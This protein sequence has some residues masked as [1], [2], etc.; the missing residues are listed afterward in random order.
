MAKAARN[1]IDLQLDRLI[2]GVALRERL[3][4][5]TSEHGGDGSSPEIRRALLE[6]LKA[7][8]RQGR[9][10]AE[11]LLLEDG[12]GNACATRLSHLQDEII[13]CLYDFA[14][15][16][17]FR[18]PNPTVGEKITVAAVGGYGR[19]TLA[20]GSD[21]DL[22][23]LLPYKRTGLTEQ[24][25]EYMLYILWDMGFTVG[26]ATRSV[27]D[28]IRLSSEDMTIRTS[29][30]EARF[31][32]GDEAMFDTL[33][34]RF[35][36]EIVE[37]SAPEFIAAKLA[38]R[39]ARHEKSG[40]SRYRV[41]PNVKDGKGGLRDLH[42]LFWIAK[43]HYQV[44]TQTD[45][46]KR[47]VFSVKEFNRFT[48][49]QDFLWAV[50]CH[51]H[52]LTGREEERLSFDVQPVL[53]VRLGYQS[54]PGLSA[55][56]RFMKHY[57]LFAKDVGDLTRILCARLEEEQAKA[58]SGIAGMLKSLS[59][60]SRPKKVRKSDAFVSI[61]NRIKPV[62]E[63]VFA[64]DPRSL[65]TMF[66]LAE[67]NELLFHP[68]AMHLA[69][70]SLKLIDK[71]LR[72]DRQANAD[73]LA[74]LTSPKTPERTLRK[75]NESGVL[76]RFIPDFGKIVAM[77]QF[78]MY[79]HYTVDEHLLRSI[80]ILSEIERGELDDAHPLSDEIMRGTPHRVELY[81]ALLLHDIAKG[82]PEDHSIA[83]AKVA[84]RLCPR[85]GL[86]EGQ[87]R[88]VAWL[89]EQHL[90]M[91]TIAQSRDLTDP[92]TIAD[93]AKS[94]ESVDRMKL[95]IVLTVCDIKAVGPGV[96]NG[97]KGQLL[98]TLYYQTEPVLTGGFTAAPRKQQV[99]HA[100]EETIAALVEEKGVEA[101]KATAL[102]N[103]HYDNYWL[104]V[105]AQRRTQHAEFMLVAEETE[106]PFDFTIETHRFEGVT[107]LTLLVP[108]HPHLLSIIAGCCAVSDANI[109]DAQIF[110]L[111]DG[112]ALDIIALNR[113]FSEDED[114]V[115]RATR[116]ANLIRR[117]LE[118]TEN[119][120]K[121]LAG[122]PRPK[123]R[124]K[125]FTVEPVVR[126]DNGLSDKF[127]VIEVEGRDRTG[128]L[129]EITACLADRSLDIASAHISTF[130]EKVRDT[131]YVTD[132]TGQKIEQPQRIAALRKRLLSVLT[133][134]PAPTAKRSKAA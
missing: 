59:R 53:A 105:S 29:I 41:E 33:I 97:W 54:H 11:E 107:E 84:R 120:D 46:R 70:R 79:H 2:D 57:F 15:V 129:S 45:L 126:I 67:E 49:A 80:G 101:D 26:H 90:V 87:T 64:D 99:A 116:I 113:A 71:N 127:T 25:V 40:N 133:A 48:K 125:A 98:R 7:A 5:L 19:G 32:L 92:R 119:L 76:G 4:A 22:L 73:F 134:Q 83:G 122:R 31:L 106:T 108:E 115:R 37:K 78:N 21:L 121:L 13:R 65:I 56:E 89:V 88:L 62:D 16:H 77:M 68:D 95:L 100:R 102:A 124:L 93:F 36:D 47:K 50:R 52:F 91:S 34:T 81:V 10:L 42:T 74:V 43:Y 17:V 23:F 118:G 55:V 51:L 18:I 114:E 112:R 14:M 72:N 66:R 110:T 1:R 128:I 39:D 63:G 85:F 38:E 58:V 60:R 61:N 132:L 3:T 109:A 123:A 94:M 44:R 6:E 28:C 24:I 20:P 30:L 35:N 9:K 12:S 27:D 69:S 130:G 103:L 86:D 82:R 131:F 8:S 75:M 104:T 96:W 111:G 117:V